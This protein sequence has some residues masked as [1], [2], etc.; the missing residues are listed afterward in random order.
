[1]EPGATPSELECPPGEANLLASLKLRALAPAVALAA[2]AAPTHQNLAVALEPGTVEHPKRLVDHGQNAR[3]FL[4]KGR[5]PSDTAGADRAT[6]RRMKAR[7]IS[8]GFR[9]FGRGGRC[10]RAQ[11]AWPRS[12]AVFRLSAALRAV[13]TRIGRATDSW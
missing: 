11:L 1:M 10:N 5:E 13:L 3:Q 7:R 12:G 4:D 6:T 2:I 8:P 9:L